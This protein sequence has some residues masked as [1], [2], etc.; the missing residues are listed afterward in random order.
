MFSGIVE[1]IGVVKGLEYKKNLFVLKISAKKILKGTKISDSVSVDGVCL[2][3][4]KIKEGIFYF[5]VMK[6]TIDK[7]TLKYL[8]PNHGVNL[9]RALKV[10]SRLG[11]HFVSGHVD[12]VGIIKKIIT[13]PNYVE[14]QIAF[15]KELKRYLAP[16]G[17]VCIDGIS[18]TMGTVKR[19]V[20]SV[21]IIP[22]TLKIT[23]LGSKRASDKVNIETDI[24]AK[25]ILAAR[26]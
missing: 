16:K 10:N 22:H 1:G 11:G 26:G 13:L 7:T 19:N 23:T 15:N 6:E 20:F 5:D 17:S 25:Y 3:V 2:T 24:L 8:R 9:E 21:Y 4:T 14:Y 12:G 18:L